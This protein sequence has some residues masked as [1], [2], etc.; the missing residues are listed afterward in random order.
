M[1]TV[2]YLNGGHKIVVY[3]TSPEELEKELLGRR[4]SKHADL[5]VLKTNFDSVLI[6]ADQVVALVGREPGTLR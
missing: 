5:S 6:K 3:D 2:I 1:D 4:D